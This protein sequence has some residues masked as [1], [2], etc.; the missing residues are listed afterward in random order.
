MC[1]SA[2]RVRFAGTWTV[3]KASTVSGRQVLASASGGR[4]ERARELVRRQLT[5]VPMA[6]AGRRTCDS[7]FPIPDVPA[8]E[9]AK[10]GPASVFLPRSWQLDGADALDLRGYGEKVTFTGIS[11][12]PKRLVAVLEKRNRR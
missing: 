9:A 4:A 10:R 8:I 1:S 7:G 6:M 5:A 3:T 2:W 12:G 11:G